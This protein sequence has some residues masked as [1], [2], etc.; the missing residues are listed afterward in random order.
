[1]LG[2][3]WTEHMLGGFQPTVG[4]DHI[5]PSAGLNLTQHFLECSPVHIL[6]IEISEGSENRT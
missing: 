3:Y 4:L 6:H 1:M 2:R 5:L